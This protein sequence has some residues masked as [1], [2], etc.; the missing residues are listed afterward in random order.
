VISPPFVPLLPVGP[1]RALLLLVVFLLALGIGGAFAYFLH[2]IRPVFVSLKTLR[3]LGDYPVIGALSL[4][5][6]PTRHQERR[7]E[8]LGFCAG[9]GLLAV[10]LVLGLAF[11][12]PLANL[13][14]HVF[15]LGAT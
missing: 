8:V 4:I 10:V 5:E 3:E 11:N 7:R 2:K 6:S 14:Q 9:A 13:M 12:G 15:V 1:H